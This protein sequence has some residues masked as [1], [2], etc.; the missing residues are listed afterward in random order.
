M[1]FLAYLFLVLQS[2]WV[3]AQSNSNVPL[4]VWRTHL[5]T[6][7]M[8]TVS[9]LNNKIYAA[10][11][12]SSITVDISDNYIA[13]LSKIDGFTQTDIEVIRFD[14]TTQMGL[15]GYS[16]GN[17][18]ILNN[19]ILYNFDVIFRSNV[20]GS[21]KVNNISIYRLWGVY[22]RLKKESSQRIMA[23]FKTRG[24][25]KYRLCCSIKY[26]PRFGISCNAIW[27]DECSIW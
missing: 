12:K 9:I 26:K 14:Q 4:G 6:T 19:G 13:P 1:R 5:P 24:L 21:K 17:L 18:D 16:N 2:F 3:V 27:F 7:S 11:T 25:A 10:T 20:A 23:K 8:A 15:I 22:S